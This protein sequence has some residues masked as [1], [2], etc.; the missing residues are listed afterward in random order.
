MKHLGTILLATMLMA[1]SISGRT[2]TP[3]PP[4]ELA[5]STLPSV[6]PQRWLRVA[7]KGVQPVRLVGLRVDGRLIG[8]LARTTME[9][10]FQNPNGRDLE[11][12]LQL[13]LLDG[14]QVTAFALDFNGKW[15]SAVPVEKTKGRQVFEDVTRDRVDPALLEAT[16]G[17][18]FKLRVY[19]IPANGQRKVLLTIAEHLS[20][21]RDGK[22]ILRL[23]MAVGE[24]VQAFEFHLAAPGLS[25]A[26]VQTRRGLPAAA[27]K[28]DEEGVRL[29]FKRNDYSPDPLLEFA[30]EPPVEPVSTI[31]D[32]DGQ[33]YFYAELTMPQFAKALRPKPARL[34]LVWDASGSGATRE[35]EREYS[36]LARYFKALGDTEVALVLARDRA[37]A[38]GT[39]RIRGGDWSALRAV[40]ERIAYD[41]ATNPAAFV[42]PQA[43]DAVL[44][45]SDGLAN[46]GVDVFPVFPVPLLAVNAAK[47]ADLPRL[48]YAADRSGGV[49]VDLMRTDPEQATRML[50]EAQPRITKLRSGGASQLV[51][52]TPT[53]E[54]RVAIAGVLEGA[55]ASIEVV[56]TSPAGGSKRQ[57]VD[58]S[59]GKATTGFGA[60]EWARL[61]IESLEPEYELNKAEIQNIGKRFGLVTHATSL[62]VLDSVDDYVRYDILPPAEL[63]AD[64]N[65]LRDG[66]RRQLASDKAS[67]LEDIARRFKEKQAWWEKDFP[68]SDV[69]W[70]KREMKA[71]ASAAVALDRAATGDVAAPHS[72]AIPAPASAPMMEMA[73]SARIAHATPDVGEVEPTASIHLKKWQPDAPYAQRLRKATKED[74]YRIYL[75]ERPSYLDSSAFFLDAADIFFDRGEPQLAVR[76]LSNLAEMQLEN[77]H[78]LR[79]LGYRLL[80]AKRPNQAV[81]IL[82][83][84]LDL[85]PDEPQ[86][87]RDLGLALAETGQSQRAVDLLYQVATRPWHDRFPDVELI[88]L[89]ELNAIVATA[90]APL[91]TSAID[92]RL[93]RNL[94]LDLRAVLTWDADNT[95]ID[96]WVT[97]PNGEKVFYG[98]TLSYQGGHIS[99]DFTGGYGP[100]E[101][102]LKSAKPGKYLVQAQFYGHRQQVVSGAT[103]LQL[104]LTTDFGTARQRDQMVTL[105]LRSSGEVVT[106]GEFT[107][108]ER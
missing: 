36:L 102:S 47:S 85:A 79:I 73:A 44:L 7:D 27:W 10:T 46:F 11:G 40:L 95:D 18:N 28:V 103:T 88:A 30:F 57:V 39:F 100:E 9:L 23:P 13:P 4:T 49:L 3:L 20:V 96:L 90:P 62:I 87:Y 104:R 29:D 52:S 101:F 32:N 54:G 84:V 89:A 55:D 107:V 93:L 2:T 12:E 35:H 61:R 42:P 63:R 77:R 22:A 31:E 33:R 98:H 14:Q 53:A 86:S 72:P 17:N 59:R 66:R 81:P 51:A 25:V 75:G 80:Q 69:P 64:F 43:A 15:R 34:A 38:A 92:A 41:G 21:D 105:R 60:Q 97:D 45:F 5:V 106:V 19:P 108:G 56:W 8:R 68:K 99:R 71:P 70:R 37:E 6:A 67:H 50:R 74:L 65:R 78:L 76:I 1:V 91:D 58:V 24:P 48:R 82:A 16:T 94:P 83:R 26:L